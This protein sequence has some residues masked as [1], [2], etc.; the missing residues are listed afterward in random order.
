MKEIEVGEN[1][2]AIVVFVPMPQLPQFHKLIREGGLIEELEKKF[3]G[4]SV[5][6]IGQV[7]IYRAASSRVSAAFFVRSRARRPLAP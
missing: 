2:K 5:S 3:S 1:K 6:I 7:N 4:K